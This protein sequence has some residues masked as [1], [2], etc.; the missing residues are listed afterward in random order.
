MG[1][2]IR[3]ITTPCVLGV[4]VPMS[5]EIYNIN[6]REQSTSRVLNVGRGMDAN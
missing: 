5:W 6:S 2:L 1:S 3:L 4:S